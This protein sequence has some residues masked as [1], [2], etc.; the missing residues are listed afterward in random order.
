MDLID[1]TDFQQLSGDPQKE[2]GIGVPKHIPIKIKVKNLNNE[3][4]ANDL[5]VEITNKSDKPIYYLS[6]LVIP[7]S[8]NVA[9]EKVAFWLH[10]DDRN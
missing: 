4:W 8:E 9:D 2:M 1:F 3:K 7:Q 6:F 10:Y 5:E